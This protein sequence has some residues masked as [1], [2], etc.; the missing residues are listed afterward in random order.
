MRPLAS[1][2]YRRPD[3]TPRRLIDRRP[4][5][6]QGSLVHRP[7]DD[8]GSAKRWLAQG[9]GPDRRVRS[10]GVV[11]FPGS[12]LAILPVRLLA[13]RIHEFLEF[14]EY[15]K[16]NKLKTKERKIKERNIPGRIIAP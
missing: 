8:Q 13:G 4:R 14:L 11:L 16:R 10:P 6:G 9:A 12:G 15:S 5:D 7:R 3:V 1:S 2:C